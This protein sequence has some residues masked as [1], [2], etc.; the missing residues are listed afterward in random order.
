MDTKD[1]L[2]TLTGG[3]FQLLQRV[4]L[5]HF[6]AA[7]GLW[8]VTCFVVFRYV[9][10]PFI[11]YPA[12]KT[13]VGVAVSLALGALIFAYGFLTACVCAVRIGS[14]A[15]E[16][17]LDA[18]FARVQEVLGAKVNDMDEGIS[19]EQAR[20]L[21]SGS[22]RDV[23]APLKSA[24][25]SS[26]VRGVSALLLGMMSLATRSVLISKVLKVSG[27]SVRLSKVFAG[28]ATLVGAIVLNLH[29]LAVVLLGA[30]YLAGLIVLGVDFAVVFWLQ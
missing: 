20:I 15:W 25:P 13:G 22:V 28:R 8:L 4:F 17:F 1:A 30:L 9:I 26:L 29:F 6:A 19:K 12:L 10:A 21:V 18:Q 11:T 5:P 24:S 23:F 3:F 7:F 16:D 14:S 2:R 27:R